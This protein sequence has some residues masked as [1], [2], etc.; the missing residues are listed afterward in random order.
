[1]ANSSTFPNEIDSFLT[2]SEILA[3][4]IPYVTR[5]Q[6]LKLKQNRTQI[7]ETE[8]ASL[9][10]QLR[11]KFI[12]A[13]DFNKF[14]DALVNMEVFI[15]DNVEGYIEK[16]QTEFNT[17]V[18]TKKTEVNTTV[19]NGSSA[20]SSAKDAAL[21]SIDNKMSSVITYLDSTTAGKLRNDIGVLDNL[22]TSVKTSLVS[23]VNEVQN[24]SENAVKAVNEVKNSSEI[25]TKAV[26]DSLTTH[27]N[28]NSKHVPHLG[29]TTNSGDN[30]IIASTESLGTNQK[31]TIKFNTASSTAPT[32]NINSGGAKSIKRA[33]G[34]NAKIYASVYTLFW[35]GANFILLGEG[36]GGTA[37]AGDI[38][39]GKTAETDAGSVTGTLPV[40][41]GGVI[42]PAKENIT[43]QA[44]I[45]DNDIVVAGVPV[46]TGAL[47]EGNTVAGQTG[48]MLNRSAREWHQPGSN[49]TVWS[50]DR[51]FIMPPEGYYNGQSWVTAPVPGLVPNNLRSGVKVGDLTGT[52]QERGKYTGSNGWVEMQSTVDAPWVINLGIDP[53]V[54]HYQYVIRYGVVNVNNEYVLSHRWGY[55]TV[56]RHSRYE[57]HQ[58]MSANGV[59]SSPEITG[60][61][62]FQEYVNEFP[63]Q[64]NLWNPIDLIGKDTITA[65]IG[66]FK[67]NQFTLDF[68]YL[69]RDPRGQNV[70][71]INW[72]AQ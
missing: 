49:M 56:T 43:R 34:N 19:N 53:V 35:D 7:E 40:R 72:L 36:G 13:D 20:I 45:Y 6:E 16:K 66:N 9:S 38:R 57:I 67:N 52:L 1:M 63:D 41:T 12:S 8:F 44:G 14:Q 70:A 37:V 32:L 30:Y 11:N 42:T 69:F 28:N 47:L 59:T 33:N 61:L 62:G 21:I 23:A 68:G 2:H 4:D 51:F 50:G 17:F 65:P 54:F 39:S 22:K 46:N 24:T 71:Y 55:G 64:Y 60:A 31:F 5:F 10:T 25:A 15:K 27:I 29:T 48:A 58:Y 26:N 3:S 18:N